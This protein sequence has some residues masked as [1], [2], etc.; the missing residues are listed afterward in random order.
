MSY[1]IRDIAS[2]FGQTKV[3]MTLEPAEVGYGF[4]DNSQTL[5]LQRNP[6]GYKFKFITK[7]SLIP[8]FGITD[9]SPI[10]IVLWN[11]GEKILQTQPTNSNIIGNGWV[12]FEEEFENRDATG[13]TTF[14]IGIETHGYGLNWHF[15]NI[16]VSGISCED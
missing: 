14:S 11:N 2:P 3:F 1:D 6:Y 15:D 7:C 10:T 13:D 8:Q 4:V 16:I 5:Q 9:W 12:S